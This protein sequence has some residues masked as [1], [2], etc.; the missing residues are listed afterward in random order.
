MERG[1][2]DRINSPFKGRG[3]GGEVE[4]NVGFSPP[5]YW[6]FLVEFHLFNFTVK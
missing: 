4:A 5:Q 6:G 2:F 3:A 1:A